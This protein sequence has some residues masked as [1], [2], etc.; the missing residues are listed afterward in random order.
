L[1]K[2]KITFNDIQVTKSTTKE[3]PITTEIEPEGDDLY[4][5]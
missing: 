2:K 4:E 3:A 1:K 5:S